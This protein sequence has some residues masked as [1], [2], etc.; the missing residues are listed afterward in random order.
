MQCLEGK[1]LVNAVI[2]NQKLH[3]RCDMCAL[4]ASG[5]QSVLIYVKNTLVHLQ[6]C[7]C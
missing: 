7:K 5:L 1:R 6:A 4:Q 2:V 3:P